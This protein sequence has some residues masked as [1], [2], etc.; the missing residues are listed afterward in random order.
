MQ[1]KPGDVQPKIDAMLTDY[2]FTNDWFEKTARAGWQQLVPIL[3]P[4]TY[5][6]I[7]SYEGA[8]L[9]WICENAHIAE[10]H[11]IDTWEGGGDLPTGAHMEEVEKRFLNNLKILKKKLWS[12]PLI[13]IHKNFSINVLAEMIT[14]ATFEYFDMI[15]IDGSHHAIDVLQDAVMAWSLL[16]MDGLMIFDDYLWRGAPFS[17]TP[18]PAIDAFCNIHGDEAQVVMAGSQIALARTM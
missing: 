13:Y 12:P 16:K 17:Q 4:K 18:K 2:E 11:C 15:Y 5:L 8:S 1:V 3:K 6:E 7:G 10:A 9:T 14:K